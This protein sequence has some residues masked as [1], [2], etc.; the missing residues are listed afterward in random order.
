LDNEVI[1]CDQKKVFFANAETGEMRLTIEPGGDVQWN[2]A[3]YENRV[4]VGLKDGTNSGMVRLSRDDGSEV[5][6]VSVKGYPSDAGPLLERDGK[7]YFAWADKI[8]AVSLKDGKVLWSFQTTGGRKV[9]RGVTLSRQH[10]IFGS[11]RGSVYALN[12]DDGSLAWRFNTEG[13]VLH[14]PVPCK[15]G[16]VFGSMKGM[17][18]C[19]GDDTRTLLTLLMD[20]QAELIS[21]HRVAMLLSRL[22]NE[23]WKVRESA[24]RHLTA[25]MDS[26]FVQSRVKA[27]STD[28]PEVKERL[29]PILQR[30]QVDTP[31]NAHRYW[32]LQIGPD[33]MGQLLTLAKKETPDAVDSLLV[34]CAKALGFAADQDVS[35]K[36]LSA[37]TGDWCITVRVD[38]AKARSLLDVPRESGTF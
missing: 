36:T 11:T 21:E 35:R 14:P 19:I 3:A 13:E 31:E 20:P 26:R 22:G 25:I 34:R 9:W 38:A 16:F 37:G 23:S 32:Y 12:L 10:A 2:L 30:E 4:Y 33:T 15:L 6:R 17:V 24:T 5:W 27:Y 7:G 18:V 1:F 8:H 28:D 29:R